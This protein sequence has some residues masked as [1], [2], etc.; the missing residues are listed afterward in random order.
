MKSAVYTSFALR[1]L[2]DFFNV[3]LFFLIPLFYL[4]SYLIIQ[5][6]FCDF[7][8]VDGAQTGK[9]ALNPHFDRFLDT[10]LLSMAT[11]SQRTYSQSSPVLLITLF[12]FLFLISP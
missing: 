2:K 6:F 9:N 11:F 4:F 3:F 8:G 1:F 12:Y 10:S 7:L 5:W